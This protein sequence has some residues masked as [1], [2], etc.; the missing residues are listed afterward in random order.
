MMLMV[1]T[2]LP[3][4]AADEVLDRLAADPL[5]SNVQTAVERTL[6]RLAADPFDRRLGTTAFQ[7]P[8]LGAISATPVRVD[9]WYV[10]WRRGARPRSLVIVLIHQLSVDKPG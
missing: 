10:F 6:G 3:R 1:Y 9:D 5:L 7:L 8:T 2:L 4:P